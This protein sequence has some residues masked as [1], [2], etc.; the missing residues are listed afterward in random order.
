MF[1][2]GLEEGALART[3][4]IKIVELCELSLILPAHRVLTM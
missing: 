3:L 1:V 2:S 4:K